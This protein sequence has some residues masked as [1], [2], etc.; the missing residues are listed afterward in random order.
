[1]VYSDY[2]QRFGTAEKNENKDDKWCIL[3]V[4]ETIWKCREQMKT[5]TVNCAFRRYFQRFGTAEK[6]ENKDGIWCIL[7]ICND[8]E[9]QKKMKTRTI[10]GAF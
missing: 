4:F 3:K 8:L 10:N 1:M 5:M 7:I 9:L 2:L 6:I